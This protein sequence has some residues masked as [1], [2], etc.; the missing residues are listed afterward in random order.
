MFGTLEMGSK[1][2]ISA[3]GANIGAMSH[4]VLSADDELLLCERDSSSTVLA[5][6][7]R[8]IDLCGDL[9]G[10]V[11][12]VGCMEQLE[13]ESP[14]LQVRRGFHHLPRRKIAGKLFDGLILKTKN[15]LSTMLYPVSDEEWNR[16]KLSVCTFTPTESRILE[17]R[18]G[19]GMTNT[20]ICK[21]LGIK[22]ATLKTHIFRINRKMKKSPLA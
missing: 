3:T 1:G 22:M 19:S 17:L 7:E 16:E 13:S 9:T 5:Q 21:S 14:A 10:R 15:G 20:E 4:P 8:C 18:L 2:D 6:N 11:C 12:K